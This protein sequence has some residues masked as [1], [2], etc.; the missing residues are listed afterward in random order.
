AAGTNLSQIGPLAPLLGELSRTYTNKIQIW[1]LLSD[2]LP[3]RSNVLA[4]ASSLAIHL[5]VLLDS[6]G[7]AARS[8]GL[9]RVGEVAVIRPPAF[10]TVYRGEVVGHDRFAA[11]GS[12][13]G[14]AL[15]SVMGGEPITYLRTP[16]QGTLLTHV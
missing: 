3:V 10:T 14:Q 1:I 5:P 7:L 13:L 12:W 8:V 11:P 6:F 2:P 16:V 15:A 4:Q 9:T